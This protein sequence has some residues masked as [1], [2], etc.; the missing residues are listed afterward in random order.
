MGSLTVVEHL[1]K[2][3][4][5]WARFFT[6]SVVPVVNELSF[7]CAEKAFCYRIIITVALTTHTDC[8]TQLSES[9]LITRNNRNNRGQTTV[10]IGY[11][12]FNRV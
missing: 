10:Y 9:L 2:F 11:R 8:N 5:I 6:V 1:N 3:K 7:E 12:F 4:Y